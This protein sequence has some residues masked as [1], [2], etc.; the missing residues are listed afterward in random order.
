MF[1]ASDFLGDEK[2][3]GARERVDDPLARQKI[4]CEGVIDPVFK[5]KLKE[6]AP[7][8]KVMW[9][10][11][12]KRWVF[13]YRHPKRT[14]LGQK[15]HWHDVNNWYSGEPSKNRRELLRASMAFDLDRRSEGLVPI[16]DHGPEEGPLNEKIILALALGDNA[17]KEKVR[18]LWNRINNE[19]VRRGSGQDALDKIDYDI[20]QSTI[21]AD[22]SPF[23]NMIDLD[24]KAK[25]YRDDE[26]AERG[27][28]PVP[29]TTPASDPKISVQVK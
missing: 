4:Q 8:I 25:M 5:R 20:A 29:F 14:N 7:S 24:S 6:F 10:R 21:G 9:N 12:T 26:R 2:H 23:K 22:D 13:Y 27:A 3:V 16:M 15:Q 28:A 18:G 19:A 11:I 17:N 1:T